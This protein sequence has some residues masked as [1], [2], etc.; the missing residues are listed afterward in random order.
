MK[1]VPANKLLTDYLIHSYLYY[2][3][4]DSV[5]TDNEFDALAKELSV[6]WDEVD[7]PHKNL[8]EIESLKKTSSGYYITFPTIVKHCAQTLQAEIQAKRRSSA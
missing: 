7:H 8:V 1:Q 4:A 2:H 3:L 6:R 5:L